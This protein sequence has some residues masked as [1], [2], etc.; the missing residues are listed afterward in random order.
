MNYLPRCLLIIAGTF[1]LLIGANAAQPITNNLTV[2]LTMAFQQEQKENSKSFY[3]PAPLIR[4]FTTKDLIAQLSKSFPTISTNKGT[5]LQAVSAIDEENAPVFFQA[6]NADGVV[7]SIPSSVLS[8]TNGAVDLYSYTYPKSSGVGRSSSLSLLTI[9]Y[10]DTTIETNQSIN[11][12]RFSF[13]G[14]AK[15]NATLTPTQIPNTFRVIQ[16]GSQRGAT[17]EGSFLN[18]VDTNASVITT[19][20]IITSASF[21][22][23]GSGI[24]TV[25]P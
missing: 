13:N 25:E 2:A 3:T 17:G 12:L 22:I 1:T 10:N 15:S 4:K 21:T 14:V 5:V 18:G 8:V 24:I 19:D 6:R 7:T 9:V 20:F 16:T 11:G 23:A